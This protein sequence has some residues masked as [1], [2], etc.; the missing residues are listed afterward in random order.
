V[1]EKIEGFF[2]VCEARRWQR[3]NGDSGTADTTIRGVVIPASN[4]RHL[5]LRD[6][7]VAAVRDGR[8]VV[9]A[10]RTVDEAIAWLAS[11]GEA[12]PDVADWVNRLDERIRRRLHELS[13]VRQ[14]FAGVSAAERRRKH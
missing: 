5:V 12:M 4:V 8:F 2:E 9:L 6:D 11:D 10:A 7:V 13:R 1:N 3:G 14:R